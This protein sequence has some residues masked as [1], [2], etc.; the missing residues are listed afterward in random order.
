MGYGLRSWRSSEFLYLLPLPSLS[1]D[2]FFA[3]QTDLNSIIGQVGFSRDLGALS[4][5]FSDKEQ[6]PDPLRAAFDL[7]NKIL[8]KPK[9]RDMVLL[10]LAQ[11]PGFAWVRS[12]PT[13]RNVNLR[14]IFETFSTTAK[15]FLD[16]RRALLSGGERQAK[17]LLDHC[18]W[19]NMDP[20]LKEGDR[21]SDEEII[22]QVNTFMT[23]GESG[24]CLLPSLVSRPD[25]RKRQR[26]GRHLQ[27][28]RGFSITFLCQRIPSIRPDS[29]TRCKRPLAT[30]RPSHSTSSMTLSFLTM[31]SRSR[32]VSGA[33]E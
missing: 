17:D 11:V 8:L 16:E 13:E 32:S 18:V 24:S 20:K 12:L 30:A 28:C 9:P 10:A 29:E 2:P 15:G 1:S 14:N 3:Y 25:E 33:L 31:S 22:A 21:M 5:L 19:A 4:E 6:A 23:G 26:L 7:L 27:A